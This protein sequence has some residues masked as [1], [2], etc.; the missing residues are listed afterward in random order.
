MESSIDIGTLNKFSFTYEGRRPEET[1]LYKVV[2]ENFEKVVSSIE[3]SGYGD[4][5]PYYIKNE[6]KKFLDCGILEKGFLRVH[7]PQCNSN[8]LVAFSCKTRGICSVC[9]ARRMLDTSKHLVE[10]VFPIGQIRQ[11]VI[12]FP[13]QI[14][15]I[16]AYN[17]E[18][19][20][21]LL[22]IFIR[23]VSTFYIAKAKKQKIKDP[24]TAAVTFIQ[25]FGG[26]AAN[27]NV[28]FHTLFMDGIFYVDKNGGTVFKNSVAPTNDDVEKINKKIEKRFIR[29]L[30]KKGFLED[31]QEGG[32]QFNYENDNELMAAARA[33]SINRKIGWGKN[34]G[35]RIE[36]IGAF[37]EVA[38][39]PIKGARVSY[40]N[41]FSL[42]ANV[43]IKEKERKALEKLCRYT[44]RPALANSRISEDEKGNIIYELK[45]SYTDGTTH[46]RLTKEDFIEKL[47]AIIPPP[48]SNLVRYHGA[49][50]PN[51]KTRKY[52]VPEKKNKKKSNNEDDFKNCLANQLKRKYWTPWADLLKKVFKIDA[53]ICKKCGG[54][55]SIVGEVTNPKIIEKILSVLNLDHGKNDRESNNDSNI[56]IDITN[57]HVA[58]S[59]VAINSD[60]SENNS[61]DPPK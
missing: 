22:A 1:T 5:L 51:S 44:A 6:F 38:W 33:A 58:I 19:L 11:W 7:C 3:N 37:R 13:F 25:R 54:R 43:V 53:L 59:V 32:I 9:G 18:M 10:N 40:I 28:H 42:H 39:Q 48:R 49:F 57:S 35:K 41:G 17:K 50:A 21:K 30:K 36:R 52:V 15:Y 20:N 12:S 47:I 24:E 56:K 55:M 46:L 29:A 45:N 23:A 2:S 27:L 61:V 8:K 34:R 60:F 14:R 26:S 31:Y 4:G 16:L